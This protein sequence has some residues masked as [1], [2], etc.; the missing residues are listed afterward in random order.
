[1]EKLKKNYL[2]LPLIASLAIFAVCIIMIFIGSFVDLNI[3][4]S[5]YNKTGF[6]DFVANY[7]DFIPAFVIVFAGALL[8]KAFRKKQMNKTAWVSLVLVFLYAMYFANNT[9]GKYLREAFGYGSENMW[10]PT[11]LSLFYSFILLAWIAPLCYFFIDDDNP[12]LLIKIALL[13]LICFISLEFINA[14]LKEIISRPRFKYL[15][16][17]KNDYADYL[18]WWVFRPYAGGGSSNFGSAPSKHMF[19]MVVI[20]V[21]PLATKVFKYRFKYI[22]WVVFALCVVYAFLLGYNRIHMGAHFLTDVAFG[23]LLAYAFYFFVYSVMFKDNDFK[24]ENQKTLIK[25]VRKEN[26]I[27]ESKEVKNLSTDTDVKKARI[28]GEKKKE[29]EMIKTLNKGGLE[30]KRIA[31]LLKKD[32]GDILEIINKK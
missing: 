5:L 30:A 22:E 31:K 20:F 25:E 2:G 4:K 21:L 28:E 11:I 3:S 14:F 7:S 23:V 32:V 1:M 27:E 17:L 15:H 24:V 19:V 12:K 18:G 16:G 29:E 6:G 8:F 26:E 13:I 10:G 9:M